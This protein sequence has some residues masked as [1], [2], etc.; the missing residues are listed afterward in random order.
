MMSQPVYVTPMQGYPMGFDS[1]PQGN[2]TMPWSRPAQPQSA[3]A[4]FISTPRPAPAAR[5]IV[6]AKGAEEPFPSQPLASADATTALTIP[7]PE[8]LGISPAPLAEMNG[9]DW[10]QAHRDLERLASISYQLDK[11]PEGGCRFTCLLLT[12]QPGFTHRVEAEAATEA[13][14]VRLVLD[15]AKEW[16]NCK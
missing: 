3:P 16:A 4:S 1:V 9:A 6:R 11:L 12:S 13:E 7:P 15:K 14:A 2:Q 10:T 8:E 5:P